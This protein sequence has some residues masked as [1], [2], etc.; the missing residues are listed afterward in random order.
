MNIINKTLLGAA[1]IMATGSAFADWAL[2]AADSRLSFNFVKKQHVVENG[3]FS[4]L[5]GSLSFTGKA[6][7]DIGLTTVDTLVAIRD[8]RLQEFL[9]E[10]SSHPTATYSAHIDPDSL[11][12]LLQADS[13]TQQ[14]FILN[15][16]LDLHGVSKPLNAD[17]IVTKTGPNS[18]SVDS[19]QPVIV[20]ADDY[21]LVAG[22]DKLQALAKL[23][24]IAHSVPVSFHLVFRSK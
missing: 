14:T 19:A 11:N 18:L 4:T 17:V 1:L 7:L 12:I 24:H 23:D 9:F 10:T 5:S 20:R 8:Q 21:G 22:I 15:G 16:H 13:G 2:D 6:K 3:H